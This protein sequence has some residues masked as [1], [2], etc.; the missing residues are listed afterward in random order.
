MTMVEIG[1]FILLVAI[2]LQLYVLDE[3]VKRFRNKFD[4]FIKQFDCVTCDVEDVKE[5]Q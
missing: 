3:R 1:T 2:L 4:D 5:V